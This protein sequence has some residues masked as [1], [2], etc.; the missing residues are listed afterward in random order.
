MDSAITS[1]QQPVPAIPA[2]AGTPATR[3]VS[4]ALQGGGAHGAF[5]W[6]VLDRLLEDGRLSFEGISGTSAGAI[7]GAVLAYGLAVGG[8]QRAREL[9]DTFWGRVA[10]QA[11]LSPFQPTWLDRLTGNPHLEMSPAYIGFDLLIRVMSP[12]QFNPGGFNPLRDTLLGVVD[13][14]VLREMQDVRLYVSATNVQKGK[15]KVFAGPELS[16]DALLASTCLPFL[17]TAVEINGEYYWDGGYMGNPTVYPL[18]HACQAR[19][20]IVVQINPIN[21]EAVPRTPTAIVDR[22]N[23]IS[24]NSTFLREI[25]ALSLI[26]RLLEQSM[27]EEGTCGLRPVFMHMIGDELQMQKY[28]VS[29]KL[30]ADWCFVQTL[31]KLGRD[32]ADKWLADHFDQ[33]GVRSTFEVESMFA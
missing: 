33:I 4:L 8:R 5:T 15:L 27:L 2:G 11:S 9:L 13:F 24:F 12:Y 23:E 7:N 14:K 1:D 30:N 26:N 3:T 20:V 21:R 16:V 22:M 25:R 6:G 17:F 32:A 10:H 31:R 29:S 19:D 18:I 28:G